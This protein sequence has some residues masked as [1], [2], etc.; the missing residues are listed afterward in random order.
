VEQDLSIWKKAAVQSANSDHAFIAPNVC[1]EEEQRVVILSIHFNQWRNLLSFILN[2]A[3]HYDL[4]SKKHYWIYK[5][6]YM[7]NQDGYM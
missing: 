4:L 2:L 6:F 5:S 3:I 1:I 7:V